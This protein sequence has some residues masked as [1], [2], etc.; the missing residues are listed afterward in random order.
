[1]SI[2]RHGKVQQ[3]ETPHAVKLSQDTGKGEGP[4]MAD[5]NLALPVAAQA[6]MGGFQQTSLI[7]LTL[8]IENGG[9]F[10]D[11]KR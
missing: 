7:I 9:H 8:V 10:L 4:G 3:P 5:L 6:K 1:M 11:E 2:H